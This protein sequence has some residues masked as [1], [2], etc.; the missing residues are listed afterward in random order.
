MIIRKPKLKEVPKVKAFILGII[1]NDFGYDFNLEWHW[2]IEDLVKT[3]LTNPRSLLLV[4][5]EDGLIIGTIGA[6]PYDKSYPEF[7]NK[8][9]SQNTLG[10]WRHYIEKQSRNQ[11]IGKK[12]FATVEEFAKAKEYKLLYLHT[13]KTIPGSKEYWLKRGF[14]ITT[15]KDDQWQTVHMEKML[16]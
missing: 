16:L 7:A 1:K 5:I 10:I 15:E 11:G 3:Y 9:N 6:R 8:Y 4:V 2:D 14:Q 12:M 13:Q